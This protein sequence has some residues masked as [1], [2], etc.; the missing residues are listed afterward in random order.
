MRRREFVT[1]FGGAA[2]W[3]LAA[4]AQPSG[5]PVIGYLYPGVPELSASLVSAFRRGLGGSAP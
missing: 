1:V 3:P 4:S 2:A 5:L